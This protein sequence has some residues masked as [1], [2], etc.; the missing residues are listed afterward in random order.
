M[1]RRWIIALALSWGISLALLAA[2]GTAVTLLGFGWVFLYGDDPW[3]ARFADVAIPV[4]A[5]LA[6][7]GAFFGVIAAAIHITRTRPQFAQRI[8]ASYL[9]RWGG[10]L[11]PLLLVGGLVWSVM[12]GESDRASAES[13]AIDTA[14]PARHHL[15][16]SAW[17]LDRETGQLRIDMT[18]A[19]PAEGS[20]SLL[21]EAKASGLGKP[22][23]VGSVREQLPAGAVHLLLMLDAGSLA[24]RYAEGILSRSEAVQIDVTLALELSLVP[25]GLSGQEEPLRLKI[26]LTF[27][28]RPD[29][30]VE[31]YSAQL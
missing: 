24:R 15:T 5:T 23:G 14:G 21:W 17:Q 3:P 27:S 11:L 13:G 28:Y 25:V 30:A 2:F 19:G 29:G 22:L 6:G 31:F 12:F 1:P 8:Q 26:P 4:A 7:T 20:Y 9:L 10:V 18:A 16:E